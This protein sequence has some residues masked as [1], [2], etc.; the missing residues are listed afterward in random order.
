V[1]HLA[2]VAQRALGRRS[3]DRICPRFGLHFDH[4]DP[5]PV[6]GSSSRPLALALVRSQ[7][8]RQ[9]H[10]HRCLAAGAADAIPG[11]LLRRSELSTASPVTPAEIRHG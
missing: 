1:L 10:P 5:V 7:L 3:G 2:A 8:R 9:R 11:P 6:L 4:G